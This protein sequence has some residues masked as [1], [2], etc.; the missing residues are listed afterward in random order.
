MCNRAETPFAIPYQVDFTVESKGRHLDSTK[1][2]LVW[3]FGFAHPPAVF[4]HLFDD[5]ED[6]LDPNDGVI[7]SGKSMRGI[8]C[9]GREH[10]IILTW[11]VLTG[12]AHIYVDS[13]VI[14]RNEPEACVGGEVF[15]MFNAKFRRGFN[16]P[17]AQHNGTH[18]IS[19]QCYAM[20]PMGAKSQIVN[21]HGET[22]HQYD[23]CV[24]GLSYFSMPKMYELGTDI[25][26]EKISRWGMLDHGGNEGDK[27]E[28]PRGELGHWGGVD[29]SPNKTIY[30]DSWQH[31]PSRGGNSE[32]KRM[33]RLED[34]HYFEKAKRRSSAEMYNGYGK[35]ISKSEYK[36]MSPRSDSE[37]EQM[38]RIAMDASLKDWE[39]KTIASSPPRENF[40][41]AV[42][43][44]PSF[45]Y[46]RKGTTPNKLTSIR[47]DNL[48][49]FGDNDSAPKP[50]VSQISL[51]KPIDVS[52]MDDDAT[53]TSF[54][55]NT[56]WNS[57]PPR[58]AMP[59]AQFSAGAMSGQ[60]SAGRMYP[61]Q[62]QGYQEHTFCPPQQPYVQQPW[63]SAGTVSSTPVTPRGLMPAS[64][65]SFAV[66]PP[67]TWD[68][69][70]YAFGSS[71]T[72]MLPGASV[73]GGGGGYTIT[74]N[75]PAMSPMSTNS[76]GMFSPMSQHQRHH[77][78]YGIQQRPQPQWQSQMGGGASQ[79]A[80]RST[81]M[82][83]PLRANHFAS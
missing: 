12:K 73:A 78:Q 22:F 24:D 68:D 36:E 40:L 10:E 35:T 49:D 2:K 66:P 47:E 43:S 48:I 60:F 13:K 76:I 82:F 5:N 77:Q 29:I 20:M 21:D 54:M 57:Q 72:S 74:T 81:D 46:A 41:D 58:Q 6:L 55:M 70:N 15:N 31:P 83:D 8:E 25:M 42:R 23:L 39:K 18:R 51:D 32:F 61:A 64:D 53:T 28:A 3:K 1:R 65:A 27:G 45:K 30:H 34:E 71:M 52:V 9:R 50:H 17:D 4:P 26:W 56:A 37:E 67:P 7:G 80:A 38:V 11:S 14:F 59:L 79:M 19:I 16:L 69:Y 75:N 44:E 33:G 63:S 62:Q